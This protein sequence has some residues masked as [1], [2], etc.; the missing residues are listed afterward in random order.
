M[1]SQSEVIAWVQL[2]ANVMLKR[3]GAEEYRRRELSLNQVRC[4]MDAEQFKF[5]DTSELA[6][7]TEGIIGQERAVSAIE[8]GLSMNEPGYNLFVVGPVGTGKT[9]YSVR[10]VKEAAQRRSVPDDWCYVHNFRNPDRP[11]ALRFPPG[12]VHR[13]RQAM[14][15]LVRDVEQEL[16]RQFES[17]E[18][19]QESGQIIK[20]Y[21][22]Q[23]SQIS[24]NV[25]IFAREQGLA[26]QRTSTGIVTVPMDENDHPVTAEQFA[27]LPDS[28]KTKFR[29]NQEL[30]EDMFDDAVRLIKM[31]QK[32]A[33]KAQQTLDE[34]TASFAIEHLFED[35]M[36]QF[37]GD[38]VRDYLLQLKADV[39]L[40]HPFFHRDQEGEN[41]SQAT[42][43]E[44]Q[45]D[46]RQRY[47]VNIIVDQQGLQGAPVVIETNP[48]FFNLFGKTEYRGS[49][50][51][52][53]SDYRLIKP[54]SLHRANGGYLIVQVQ[55]LLTHPAS[56]LGLKRALKN[57]E[58]QIDHP[59]EETLLMVPSGLRP[60]AIPLD[61]KI[62]LIG[63]SNLYHLLYRNDEA[64]HKY[65]KVKVEFDSQM[66]RTAESCQKY[67]N[68]VASYTTQH[69]MAPFSN[70]AMAQLI[71]YSARQAEHHKKLST[72]FN[73]IIDLITEAAFYASKDHAS[74][75]E[76]VHVKQALQQKQERS[77]LIKEKV[78]EY[79][80]DGTIKIDT[81]GQRVGQINGLAVLDT[82]DFMFG[83]PHRITSRT[84][85]GQRGVINVERETSMSGQIHNKGL[86]IL[87][88]YLAAEFGQRRPMSISASLVFEQTYSMI[89][90]DSASSTE[91]YA[92][93]S[94]LADVPI[95]QEIAVTGSVDQFGDIQ[96]IGGVNEKIEGFFYV[97][98]AQGLT[99]EQGVIIPYQ[100]V[101]NLFLSDEVMQAIEKGTFHIWPVKT[102]KEGIELLTGFEA[103]EGQPFAEDTLYGLIAS[104]LEQMAHLHDKDED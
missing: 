62:I 38:R 12:E 88:G 68:F 2:E 80:L 81:K 76:D 58:I 61:V 85:L 74:R 11:L 15:Q 65:F 19:H 22:E 29:Q 66:D 50:G 71:D 53:T 37:P 59:A 69:Q 10:K 46:P 48:T 25:E 95:K 89:D 73:P 33:R 49:Q 98:Q 91:L 20:K 39:I 23:I 6:G 44:M 35:L 64:L 24:E 28:E 87:N 26:L 36:T 72:R 97:C 67:A 79:I 55:D 34:K 103:G 82:G 84:Y 3:L 21:S 51:V 47:Q 75:V 5:K 63:T 43:A 57:S 31:V 16:S 14:T 9:T 1:Q 8:F 52:M 90:G 18:Y 42:A 13:F 77:S 45:I 93:L 99:G 70:T 17:Q 32:E 94:S 40:Y 27:Q 56:W 41:S 102:V 7:L 83:Q 60:E 54:G 104:R 30:I 92:L 86:L 78:L 100:N 96:P 101:V 4:C